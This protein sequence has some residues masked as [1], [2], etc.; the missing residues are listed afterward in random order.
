[1]NRATKD[2]VYCAA[3]RMQGLPYEWDSMN[4]LLLLA[5][6]L[7]EASILHQW[8]VEVP[9]S[10][11]SWRRSREQ[12]VEFVDKALA[13][14][15]APAYSSIEVP[16]AGYVP[17]VGDIHIYRPSQTKTEHAGLVVSEGGNV[18]IIHCVEQDNV[19]VVDITPIPADW[20]IHHIRRIQDG[21]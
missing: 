8:D 7:R 15:L 19:G 6:V 1:M 13:D 10:Y 9:F 18:R 21:Q 17:Q 2:S 20:V 12:L 4:C 11:W 3:K 16:V 14:R 5:D